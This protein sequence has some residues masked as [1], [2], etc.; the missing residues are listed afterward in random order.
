MTD[1]TQE[2]YE[3]DGICPASTSGFC[4]NATQGF[5]F[6]GCMDDC[7]LRPILLVSPPGK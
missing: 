6:A 4:L 1:E 2:E 3:W 5:S 7:E